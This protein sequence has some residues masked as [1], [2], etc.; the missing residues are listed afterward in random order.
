MPYLTKMALLQIE[1]DA[2]QDKFANVGTEMVDA[3]YAHRPALPGRRLDGPTRFALL[4]ALPERDHEVIGEALSSIR[5]RV[6]G[7]AGHGE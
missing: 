4:A 6:P 2:A 3:R 1:V 7:R 5:C